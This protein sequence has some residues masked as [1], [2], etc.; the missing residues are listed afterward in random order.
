ML[1]K[2]I[3][4]A[5]TGS[6]AAYKA[7]HLTRLF[8][9]AGA[10]VQVLMTP[11]A[12]AFITPLTL[13]TLSKKTV[14]TN[15]INEDEW[16]NHVH[17]GLW[18]DAMVIAP[19]TANTLAKLANGICDNIVSAVYLSARCPVFLAP[20]MDL[21]MW[22]HP[23][24]KDNVSRLSSF[25]NH[26]IPVGFGE[27]AS[28]LTG[29]GRM[30]E[31]EDI[32]AFLNDFFSQQ[33]DFAGKR[34]LVTAGPTYE[35]L[36]PVRFIGNRSSGKMGIAI[37]ETFARRGA[38]VTLVLGPSK[39]SASHPNISTLRVETAEEMKNAAV[40]A[41]EQ[42]DVAV[43]SAAVADYRPRE[44]STQKIKKTGDHISLELEKTPDIAATLGK[45]KR[46]GQL[47]TGFA[48]ETNDEI[49]HALHK[50]ESKN[51]D[52]IVLNSLNDP[53]A[54]FNFDTNKVTILGRDNKRT[55]FELKSKADV[56]EDIVGE[57]LRLSKN[58]P[59]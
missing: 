25:G 16:A 28:G 43:L 36:D 2:K 11:A 13:S 7:A 31:P 30:A 27:L 59:S 57:I 34:V 22:Q 35:P 20:A 21:D 6:I 26:L 33:Q 54:G 24:V 38:L 50:L 10:E 9:K 55:D 44:I 18:A 19:A 29:A 41:F 48:L 58:L 32:L 49:R 37:A 15:V 39:L 8:I 14:F 56:A 52:L 17:L 12:T 5:I 45:M 47:I 40:S 46:K 4:L 51:F 42:A 23:A 3:I 1:G 53:G